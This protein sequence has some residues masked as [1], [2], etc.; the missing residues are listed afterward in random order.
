[1]EPQD[2]PVRQT[3]DL[4][5]GRIS[6]A[7]ERYFITMVTRE[8]KPW[9]TEPKTCGLALN[10]LQEWH[11]E[12][13]GGVLAAT[14]MPDHIHVLFTLGPKL[15]VGQTIA[16]WKSSIRKRIGYSEDFQR[17]FWEHMLREMEAIEDYAIYIF[18]NPYRA[19]LLLHYRIWHGWWAPEP[20]LFRFT[21]ML[22]PEGTPPR[23][24]LDWPNERFERLAHGE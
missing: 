15:T 12:G 3:D 14:V 10:V 5:R 7:G 16:R 22:A 6:N 8:R 2:F 21:A 24:W 17:D 9:L 11:T 23:E 1:M 19:G 13:N 18:M 20:S 4:H